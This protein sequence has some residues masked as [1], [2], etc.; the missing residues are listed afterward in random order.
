MPLVNRSNFPNCGL[1][2]SC[3]EGLG[4]WPAILAI[5]TNSDASLTLV[6]S[7]KRPGAGDI[8]D[9]PGLEKRWDEEKGL[10]YPKFSENS[11]S[12]RWG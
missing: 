10:F 11:C 8:I 12:L 2:L 6:V 3:L 4:T 5:S 9:F 7:W 1:S